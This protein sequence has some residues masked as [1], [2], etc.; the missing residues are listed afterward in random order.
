[1]TMRV[2]ST[3]VLVTAALFLVSILHGADTL[4]ASITDPAYW[5]MISDFSE[6]GG[7]FDFEMFMSNEVTFQMILPSIRRLRRDV[8]RIAS[9]KAL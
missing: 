2:R 7:T 6:P 3:G 4:P 9:R 5:K 1:M 8:R